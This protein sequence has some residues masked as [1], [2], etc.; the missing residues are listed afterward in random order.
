MAL[1]KVNNTE[2]NKVELEINVD[3]ETFQKAVDTVYRKQ[4]KKIN[5]PGFR[6]GKAPKH[7]IESMYG[8]DIFYNDA[9]SECYPEAYF[10]AVKEA[11]INP[12]DYPSVTVDEVCEDGFTFKAAV[13][14]RPEVKV[15][16]YKGIEA[17]KQIEKVTDEE[18]EG[19]LKRMADRNARIV[20]VEGRAAEDGD[21]AT[22]DFEGFLDGTPFEGGK[23]ENFE[24][25]LGSGQFI[26]GFEEQVI[27][28]NPGEE[29]DI[30]VTF[31]EDYQAEELK[32]KETVFKIKLH[33]LKKRELPTIDDEFVK[34][35]SEFDTLDELKK[36]IS[37]R[38]QQ[39]KD[40]RAQESLENALIDKVIEKMEAD[41]PECMFSNRV[42]EMVR[43]FE[44]RLQAQGLNLQTYLQYTG[45]EL[46]SFKK[47]FR[48]QAEKQVKI[49][50]ALDEIAK[51]EKLEATEED[52]DR[53]YKKLADAYNMEVDKIKEML[54]ADELKGD[55]LANKAIDLVKDSAKVTE[56]TK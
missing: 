11:D 14:V 54:P 12:V 40:K 44:Q 15:S 10:A 6:K 55:I 23:A 13:F 16:D 22:I 46:D 28:H 7:I 51:V 1:V 21:I 26:P 30:T 9:I 25:T 34:D 27:G 43:D 48:E 19:E 24:L 42:D 4:A 8:K 41:I 5:V 32:G 29:F 33:E 17:E 47:T 52:F 38:L 49:R 56:K 35:V 36:D 37:D 20:T 2:K 18:L 31:P 50:L 53:E 39:S 45:M 3:K